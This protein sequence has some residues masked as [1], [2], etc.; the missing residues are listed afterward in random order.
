MADANLRVMISVV[1]QASSA[2]GQIGTRLNSFQKNLS[3]MGDRVSRAGQQFAMNLTL[4][5]FLAEKALRTFGSV[6][7]EQQA[8]A[9]LELAAGRIGLAGKD[10]VE[11]LDAAA[12][13][14]VE[15]SRLMVG[16]SSILSTGLKPTLDELNGLMLIARDRGH[17]MGLSNVD[18]WDA[19]TNAIKR[20]SPFLLERLGLTLDID[21]AYSDWAF[22]Q[23]VAIDNLSEEQKA[24]AVFNGILKEGISLLDTQALSQ[25][26]AAEELQAVTVSIKKQ[27]D[28]ILLSLLPT[29]VELTEK[30]DGLSESMKTLVVGL[31][32]VAFTIG[33][34][35]MAIGGLTKLF[36]GLL[37]VLAFLSAH[38]IVLFL[39][40]VTAAIL[41]VILAFKDLGITWGELSHAIGEFMGEIKR[42]VEWVLAVP[43]KVWEFIQKIFGWGAPGF[44]PALG[45]PTMGPA[46]EF[47]TGGLV[48][49]GVVTPAI[50]HGP[51][52]II[53]L[54]QMG[55]MGGGPIINI[56]LSGTV[57]LENERS[58]D[59]FAQHMVELLRDRQRLGFITR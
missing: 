58:M 59:R 20:G 9:A 1:D 3:D 50:L 38:P 36:A 21:K 56:N 22:A 28:E 49:R 51:E 53:P 5:I 6:A 4:P 55:A 19:I 43:S 32:L 47:Q 45:G 26:T 42:A 39:G 18:A 25:R 40:L 2:L 52:A 13:G 33:P 41:Q 12:K 14:T 11:T 29:I 44:K 16:A 48:P 10:I 57:F 30:F 27:S 15:N 54:S 7:S 34:I 8:A 23:G 35:A 24:Q 37:A 31:G 46:P 17:A